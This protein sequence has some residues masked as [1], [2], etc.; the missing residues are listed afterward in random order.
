MTQVELHASLLRRDRRGW[1]EFFRRYGRLIW[2]R[3][4]RLAGRLLLELTREDEEDIYGATCL[5]LL[6]QKLRA[7]RPDR[8]VKLGTWVGMLCNQA[9]FDWVRS[10]AS[11]K[12]AEPFRVDDVDLDELPSTAAPFDEAALDTWRRLE[13]ARQAIGQ[14][15]PI[16]GRVM[17]MGTYSTDAALALELRCSVKS[18]WSARSKAVGRLRA[19][20]QQLLEPAGSPG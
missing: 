14:L 15:P 3:I 4:Q 7:W 8:G 10:R 13:R 11:A 6:G 1:A 18:I 16:Q 5:R 20:D 19:A 9:F 17:Q 12:R 2:S